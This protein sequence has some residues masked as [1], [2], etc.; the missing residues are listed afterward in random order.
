MNYS[1]GSVKRQQT[2]WQQATKTLSNREFLIIWLVPFIFG[3]FCPFLF[4]T[5]LFNQTA[6]FCVS[7]SIVVFVIGCVLIIARAQVHWFFP[8]GLTILPA[9]LLA[10][11]LGLYNWNTW[12]IYPLLYSRSR[13]YTDVVASQSAAAVED[14]GYIVFAQGTYVDIA[15]SV[16]YISEQGTNYCVAPIM[17]S[18]PVTGINFWAAG[19]G[20]C[21]TDGDFTCKG[22]ADSNADSGT[23]IFDRSD[24]FHE[25][26]YKFYK[27]A[28]AK[29][30]SIWGLSSVEGA[31]FVEYVTAANLYDLTNH[32]QTCTI[33]F[34][35]LISLAYLAFQAA[36]ASTFIERKG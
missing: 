25:S 7:W 22:A 32:Y 13:E 9:V 19:F 10:T 11:F 6:V 34:W 5:Y 27:K 31:K 18:T 26:P 17:S 14:A 16:S 12:A 21:T 1:E 2:Y 29:S 30:E 23:V 3:F 8:V 36:L 24:W 28:R 20:C 33:V 4:F 15:K 35:V